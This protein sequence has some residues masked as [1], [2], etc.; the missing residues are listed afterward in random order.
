MDFITL[1]FPNNAASVNEERL[2]F[3]EKHVVK[4]EG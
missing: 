4:R 2:S 3:G 1:D